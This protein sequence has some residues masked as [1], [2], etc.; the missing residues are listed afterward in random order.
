MEDTKNTIPE[1]D[2]PNSSCSSP[3]YALPLHGSQSRS[4][5]VARF[6]GLLPGTSLIIYS[7]AALCHTQVRRCEI[8]RVLV[9]PSSFETFRGFP[10][11][12]V[13]TIATVARCFVCRYVAIFLCF[14]SGHLLTSMHTICI[15]RWRWPCGH[16][17][18]P[19]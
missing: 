4:A 3:A 1:I 18:V 5:F 7:L 12:T 6:I 17:F 13:R 10:A 8:K 2:I 9:F 15:C 11:C 14:Y 16:V 19:N